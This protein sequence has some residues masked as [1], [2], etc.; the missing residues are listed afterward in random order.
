VN[1]SATGCE[2][3]MADAQAALKAYL[4]RFDKHKPGSRNA[5]IYQILDG[6]EFLQQKH[7]HPPGRLLLS[8][9]LLMEWIKH[10]AQT[11]TFYTAASSVR[12]LYDFMQYLYERK[13]IAVNPMELILREFGKRK[14]SGIVRAFQGGAPE[15]MLERLRVEPGFTGSFG[16]NADT[17]VRLHR[18]AGRP[19]I[20]NRYALIAFNRFIRMAGSDDIKSVTPDIVKQWIAALTCSAGMRRKR[21]LI[22]RQFFEHLCNLRVIKVSPVPWSLIDSYGRVARTFLPYIFT[23]A[24]MQALLA[25]A[26]RLPRIRPFPLCPDVMHMAIATLYTLGLRISEALNLRLADIDDEQQTLFIRQAKFYKERYVPYG[27]RFAEQLRSYLEARRVEG[28]STAGESPLF[29]RWSDQPLTAGTFRRHYVE[30]MRDAGIIRGEGP[31]PRI[32]DLRHAFAVHRL[33]RWYR[34]GV[35]VQKRLV[36]LSTFMGHVSIYS[37][38]VYLT[39][40]GNLL[41]EAN[42]RFLNA[43]GSV[44]E[45]GQPSKP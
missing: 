16:E 21:L 1:P 44:A 14:W 12:E 15:A 41:G 7:G 29:V 17:F 39:I 11:R 10:R 45:G 8:K 37:T 13:I 28:V 23:E 5:F 38:Q 30:A 3:Y 9:A 31:K 18:S 20:F 19:F 43:F 26:L 34:E 33:L 36:L 32:H 35:D 24:Q 25:A 40:T 4:E 27:P 6:L 22:L 2:L 42:K